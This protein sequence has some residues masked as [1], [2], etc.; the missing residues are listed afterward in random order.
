MDIE[1]NEGMDVTENS[2]GAIHKLRTQKKLFLDTLPPFCR[3]AY[4][5]QIKI[6]EN[7]FDT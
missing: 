5:F 2:L 1:R 7:Y 4:F 6:I 3:R